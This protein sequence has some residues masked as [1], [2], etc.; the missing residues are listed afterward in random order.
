MNVRKF[1]RNKQREMAALVDFG[2][3]GR[4]HQPFY[5]VTDIELQD[6]AYTSKAEIETMTD[7]PCLY[8]SYPMGMY[9][10]RCES[11]LRKAGYATART[12]E[13]GCNRSHGDC[14]GLRVTG[15][16]DDA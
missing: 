15:A 6:E 7:K 14:Y 1:S 9:D 10:G 3:H 4:F 5:Y 13:P 2:F 11:I 16:S 8:F 12:T